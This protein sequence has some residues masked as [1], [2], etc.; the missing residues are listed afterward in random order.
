MDTPASPAIPRLQQV[1]GA[2]HVLVDEPS[3]RFFS[4]DIF[5]TREIACVAVRPGTVEELA[6]A[7]RIATDSG[8]AV[9]ARG[10]GMSYTDGYLPDRTAAMV[11]DTKRL[12]R[13]VEVNTTDMYVTAECGISW[14]ELDAALAPHGVRTPFWGTGSGRYATIGGGLSQNAI[15]YGSGRYGPASESCLGLEVVLAD[16]RVL[17]TGSAATPYRPTPFFRHYGPDLTGLFLS[18]T[19]ALGVKARAT[20]RLIRRAPVLDYGSFEFPDHRGTIAAMAELARSALPSEMSGYDSTAVAYMIQRRSLSEDVERLA[21]VARHDGLGAAA[22]I[23][24][25][26]RRGL[27]GAAYSVHFTIEGRDQADAASALAAAKAICR[28]AGGRELEP[29]VPRIVR[30]GPFPEPTLLFNADGKQWIPVHVIVPHSRVVPLIE[31]VEEYMAARADDL[32]RLGI[33]WGNFLAPATAQALR[34]EPCLFFPDEANVLRL[35]FFDEE[36]RG[37]LRRHP[38]RP[39]VH[40]AVRQIRIDIGRMSQRFGGAHFQIAKM[41]PYRETRAPETYALLQAVKAWVDPKG[42][43]NP[44]SLG[45]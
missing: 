40:D 9:L 37:K 1:L 21:A 24:L 19:G 3:R 38:R 23:A 13:V 4:T 45:L 31:A 42:L 2:E 33:E 41:Y 17:V 8:L 25:A 26:G 15:N 34:V 11:I 29:S 39:E 14:L 32:D 28:G 5:R 27:R 36:Y 18:D 30:A 43:M 12:N 44:G 20:L 10:G 6:E 16:G 7:V 35:S 22:R